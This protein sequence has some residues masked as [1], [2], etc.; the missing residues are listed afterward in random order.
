MSARKP[1]SM[2]LSVI[3]PTYNERENIGLLIQEIYNSI[4]METEVIVV[5]DDS[6]D[7]TWAVVERMTKDYPGLKLICRQGKKGL[8]SALKEGIANSSGEVVAWMDCDLS[9][10]PSKLKELY[11]GIVE[12][13]DMVIGSRFV[14]GGGVE[15]ITGSK[16][17]VLAFLLSAL[18][19]SFV[20]FL[21]GDRIKDYT[22]GFVAVRRSLLE[23]NRAARR[24]RRIFH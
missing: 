5:D 21:L 24:L 18:L 12:G 4:G 22:S 19:N 16:D 13:N 2:R 11:E 17:T 8:V 20:R 1:A 7:G 23:K 6:P 9:M 10:P 15:I 3:L 14:P